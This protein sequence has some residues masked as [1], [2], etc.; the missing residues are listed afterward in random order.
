MLKISSLFLCWFYHVRWFER[1]WMWSVLN[2]KCL[3]WM[4]MVDK[5]NHWYPSFA[6]NSC[7]LRNPSL[8]RSAYSI[9]YK[10]SLSL[11]LIS[12]Y[13]LNTALISFIPTSPFYFL[14]NNVN[15]SSAYY[16]LPLPKNHFL[17]IRSTTSVSE[18]VYLSWCTFVI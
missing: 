7:W 5:D 3:Y 14:S 13:W 11:M 16:Y 8:S 10:M 9:N 6:K 2:G 18:N 4:V 17:V 15:I 1:R 12:R